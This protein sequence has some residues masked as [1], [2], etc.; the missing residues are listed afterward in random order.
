M[1]LVVERRKEQTLLATPTLWSYYKH[2]TII[3]DNS[4]IISEQ[5]FKLIDNARGV[6]YDHHMF[7]IQATGLILEIFDVLTK[8]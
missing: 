7:L 3:N 1:S 6:I 5:S 2:M 4:N 8:I